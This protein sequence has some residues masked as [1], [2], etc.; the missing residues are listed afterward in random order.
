VLIG[1]PEELPDQFRT[2]TKILLDQFT[3]NLITLVSMFNHLINITHHTQ[4][5]GASLVSN[6]FG[7][8]SFA[9]T[10]GTVQNDSLKIKLAF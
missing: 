7:K 5:G 1:N 3:A 6:S 10:R 4:E 8:Q 9:S 2:V